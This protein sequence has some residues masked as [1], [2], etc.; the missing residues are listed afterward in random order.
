MAGQLQRARPWWGEMGLFALRARTLWDSAGF[1]LVNPGERGETTESW[2]SK[3]TSSSKESQSR[4]GIPP[5]NNKDV[6]AA[7]VFRLTLCSYYEDENPQRAPSVHRTHQ[8]LSGP[9]S[10]PGRQGHALSPPRVEGE[11]Q[12]QR[13]S[14]TCPATRSRSPPRGGKFF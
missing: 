10:S 4:V 5:R 11:G 3:K 6:P 13:G 14:G 7:P 1:T 12:A 2:L 8:S 9:R